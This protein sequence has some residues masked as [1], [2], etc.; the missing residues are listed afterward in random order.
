MS[1]FELHSVV[2]ADCRD[3]VRSHFTVAE[4]RAREF[5][6]WALV[7]EALNYGDGVDG[8]HSSEG[9]RSIKSAT[10]PIHASPRRGAARTGRR[11]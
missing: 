2:L 9:D 5:V 7:E 1:T 8:A 3:V 10:T 4:A 11:L 6:E